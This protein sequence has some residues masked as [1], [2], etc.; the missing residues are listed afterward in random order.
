[1][2]V[3]IV[4]PNQRHSTDDYDEWLYRLGLSWDAPLVPPGSS[5]LVEGVLDLWGGHGALDG[6][7]DRL[8]RLVH[9]DQMNGRRFIATSWDYPLD[10]WVRRWP[11]LLK[12]AGYSE[13]SRPTVLLAVRDADLKGLDDLLADTDQWGLKIFWFWRA[14]T[15][16]DTEVCVALHPKCAGMSSIEQAVLVET[17]AWDLALAAHI[18]DCWNGSLSSMTE[19]LQG[20][21]VLPP[22]S[23]YGSEAIRRSLEWPPAAK[24][25][26]WHNGNA[27]EW[28]GRTYERRSPDD[29]DLRDVYWRSQLRVMFPRLERYRGQLELAIRRN[30]TP[31]AAQE[32][33][34]LEEVGGVLE[35][36]DLLHVARK[37]QL[38]LNH[39]QLRGLKAAREARNCLAH[40]EPVPLP[41]LTQLDGVLGL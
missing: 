36:G 38:R 25:A 35:L 3:V 22:V 9:L 13:G 17:V 8:A 33:D 34:R 26:A 24:R 19:L 32:L 11:T 27:D 18:A 2:S 21:Q 16:L 1:M 30:A 28:E 29:R 31:V 20:G 5:D 7:H 12:S 6:E 10:E 23:E 15:R 37:Y 40:L 39:Q 41:L 14:I 4:L